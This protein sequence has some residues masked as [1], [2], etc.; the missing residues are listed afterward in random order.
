MVAD[1][2]HAGPAGLVGS[3]VTA[4]FQFSKGWLAAQGSTIACA[5]AARLAKEVLD[6]MWYCK[7]K[8]LAIAGVVLATLTGM[9]GSGIQRGIEHGKGRP[10]QQQAAAAAPAAADDIS[11]SA[12]KSS[13]ETPRDHSGLD[14][15][16]TDLASTDE[17]TALRAVLKLSTMPRNEAVP[18][19]KEHLPPVTVDVKR[20]AA[21]L[22]DLD[23]DEFDTRQKA[24]AEL[25]YLGEYAVPY[26]ERAL[27]GKPSLEAQ[28]RMEQVLAKVKPPATPSGW[29]RSRR[30]IAVLE[31]INTEESR[32]LLES[33]SRGRARAMP[34]QDAEAALD[35]LAEGSGVDFS[36]E[37]RWAD[38]SGK[39]EGRM[40]A[41]LLALAG[42]PKK[43]LPL[44]KKQLQPDPKAPLTVPDDEAMKKLIA[45][46]DSDQFE[47]R[48]KAMEELLKLGARGTPY[49]KAAV[50][51]HPEF[52]TDKR[53]LPLLE[54]LP[55]GDEAPPVVMTAAQVRRAG[56]LLEHIGTRD[57]ETLVKE[58]RRIKEVPFPQGAQTALSPDGVIQA[59]G[60]NDGSVSLVDAK[61]GKLLARANY[62]KLAVISVAFSPDGKIVAAGSADR[63]ISLLEARSGKIIRVLS[64]D[65]EFVA[66]AFSPDGKLLR[67]IDKD[68]NEREWEVPTGQ[69]IK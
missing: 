29:V 23:A 58:L 37:T 24:T 31:H 64:N 11:T 2:A 62:H 18:F 35:R 32:K 36:T 25:E 19:V 48:Y 43:T 51:R 56:L 68:K 10:S 57:A 46:L 49:I 28:K 4:A 40:L 44:L 21:R 52:E 53:L 17:A 15:L 27:A 66:V 45:S 54:R 34:T 42:N 47:V 20:I 39:D 1:A 13:A 38:L 16:W 6:S 41:A 8:T 60:G 61:S 69:K 63:S 22:A 59:V 67:T 3:T 12:D 65:A 5:K 7:L 26:L 50:K 30:A 9:I 14:A 33:V 55:P